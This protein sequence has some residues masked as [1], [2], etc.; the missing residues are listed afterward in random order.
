VSAQ[1][2]LMDALSRNPTGAASSD[3]GA[4]PVWK[5]GGG[6]GALMTFY[7]VRDVFHQIGSL[8]EAVGDTLGRHGVFAL[9][10]IFDHAVRAGFGSVE[11]LGLQGMRFFL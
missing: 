3:E 8:T 11:A 4:R 10:D 5:G 2:L 7:A 1:R 6:W 9:P